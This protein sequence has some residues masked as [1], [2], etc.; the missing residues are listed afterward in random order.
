[1]SFTTQI[2]K[3]GDMIRSSD[4][5][6]AMQEIDSLGTGKLDLT[7][8]KLSG[9][10]SITDQLN[11]VS[12]K[13]QLI[14]DS[15]NNGSIRVKTGKETDQLSFGNGK[16]P[17]L[18]IKDGKVGVGVSSPQASIDSRNDIGISLS[19]TQTVAR[20]FHEKNDGFL[21]L[22]TGEQTPVSRIKLSSYGDSYFNSNGS[23]GIGTTNP[24]CS[25]HVKGKGK[26]DSIETHRLDISS[27]G[28][29]LPGVPGSKFGALIKGPL[30]GHVVLNIRS[31]DSNDG[32][33]VRAPKD[34]KNPDIVDKT[35]LA[36]KSNGLIGIG[37]HNPAYKLDVNGSIRCNNLSQTS[38]FRWKKQIQLIDQASEILKGIKPV[39]YYWKQEVFDDKNF[40]DRKHYGVIAQDLEVLIPELVETDQDGYKSVD[41]TS[42]IGLII[43]AFQEQQKDLDML[44]NQ[45]LAI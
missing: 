9:S 34:F 33:Y 39:S 29:A 17:T 20:L 8:G 44:K 5:N 30:N 7:G 21:E 27:F 25:L 6:A 18:T 28:N 22:F 38:D 4:W 13:N 36:V 31:N 37:H 3:P 43:K 11:V 10:L 26:F 35:V 45:R 2:K 42:L 41:Y 32:F 24:E 14:I 16:E 40:K 15:T 12:K 23:F 19:D 1:M